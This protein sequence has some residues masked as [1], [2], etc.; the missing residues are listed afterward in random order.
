MDVKYL[1]GIFSILIPIAIGLVQGTPSLSAWNTPATTPFYTNVNYTAFNVTMNFEYANETAIFNWSGTN[2]TISGYGNITNTSSTI[3]YLVNITG[4]QEGNYSYNLWMNETEA[5]NESQTTL[6]EVVMDWTNPS[7]S[8][9][10]VTETNGT[11]GSGGSMSLSWTAN[12]T[13]LNPEVC[14]VRVWS[15]NASISMSEEAGT[16]TLLSAGEYV[17]SAT[18]NSADITERGPFTIEVYG[19]D[20]AANSATGT[21]ITN[22]SVTVL[23]DAAWNMIMAD[24]NTTLYDIGQLSSKITHV[25]IYS[26]VNHNYTSYVVG[27]ITNNDTAVEEG[28]VVY[29]YLSGTRGDV[30][31][32][33]REWSKDA[34][35]ETTD[36]YKAWNQLG[37][38]NQTGWT[39]AQLCGKTISNQTTDDG[40]VIMYVSKYDS[41]T[42]T[43]KSHRC[44]FTYGGYNNL[45]VEYGESVWIMLNGSAAGSYSSISLEGG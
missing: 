43:Y 11:S 14:R 12:F 42:K 44:G 6:R 8:N 7:H 34:D 24:R 33:F 30:T 40:Q 20:S 4:Q 27:V 38:F 15:D 45:R 41:L 21:N 5:G 16:L 25:S 3:Q 35:E 19:N 10:A 18:I 23:Y 26:N 37:T 31:Y 36:L 13:E 29:V 9:E 22:V 17:C 2:M 28:D 39:F 32:L 1:L